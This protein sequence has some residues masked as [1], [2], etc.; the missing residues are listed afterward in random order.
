METKNDSILQESKKYYSDKTNVRKKWFTQYGRI[1]EDNDYYAH[2]KCISELFNL[3]DVVADNKLDEFRANATRLTDEIIKEKK[4]EVYTYDGRKVYFWPPTTFASKITALRNIGYKIPNELNKTIRQLRNDTTHGNETIVSEHIELNYERTLEILDTF[5]ESLIVL[6]MLNEEDR[7]PSFDRLR[8][9]EGASLRNGD[10]IIGRLLGEGGSSRVYEGTQKR[11][12]SRV[13]VKELKPGK[14]TK[15]LLQ[16]ESSLLVSLKNNYIPKIYDIFSE[17]GTYYIVMEYI[18]GVT[19]GEYLRSHKLSAEDKNSLAL[20]LCDIMRY[21]HNLDKRIIFSDLKPQNILVNDA[22]TPF[23]IDFGVAKLSS[24][25]DENIYIS[26]GYTAPEK[27]SNK[28]DERSDIYSFGMVLKDIAKNENADDHLLKTVDKCTCYNPNDRFQS[29]EEVHI[30]LSSEKK[31]HILSHEDSAN[32]LTRNPAAKQRKIRWIIPVAVA[33]AGA[34]AIALGVGLSNLSTGQAADTSTAASTSDGTEISNKI[35]EATNE[36]RNLYEKAFS[37]AKND[38]FDGYLTLFK[39]DENETDRIIILERIKEEFTRLRDHI[40]ND[41]ADIKNY[42]YY[43]LAEAA[44]F[45]AVG[46]IDASV[47]K[48]DDPDL[49]SFNMYTPVSEKNGEWLFDYTIEAH[50][51][52]GQATK[53]KW[54]SEIM[55]FFEENK[56]NTNR[57]FDIDDYSWMNNTTVID[58]VLSAKICYMFQD[59]NGAVTAGV[60]I[61]NGKNEKQE[62]KEIKLT[63]RDKILGDMFNTSAKGVIIDSHRSM[64]VNILISPDLVSEKVKSQTWTTPELLKVELKNN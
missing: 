43:F 40:Q 49:Y 18:D 10:Y 38:D 36:F 22:G 28:G 46:T 58:D 61:K 9:H 45:Y 19:L 54:A 55:P 6:G 31:D 24:D 60:N 37:Y 64:T 20:K 39:I 15:S 1:S 50:N 33:A 14:Y 26:E 4:N 63:A 13:A 29:F 62:V 41:N 27:Y 23:L 5:A 47:Y 16:N 42:I 7:H 56:R 12:G 34:A 52:I 48:A 53:D 57:W 2:K 17:N 3:I 59:T 21:L 25:G 8:I 11:L 51:T 30:S 35:F 32:S 44:P